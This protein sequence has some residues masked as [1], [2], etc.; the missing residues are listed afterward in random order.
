[1]SRIGRFQSFFSLIVIFFLFLELRSAPAD[2]VELSLCGVLGGSR[3]K[4]EQG[5]LQLVW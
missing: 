3:G 5:C 1:M 4:D 2:G